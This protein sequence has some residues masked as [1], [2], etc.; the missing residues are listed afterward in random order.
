MSDAPGRMP[1]AA[2]YLAICQQQNGR[3]VE[4]KTAAKTAIPSYRERLISQ[5]FSMRNLVE[6]CRC[7]I[8]DEKEQ[9]AIQM[10]Q[11]QSKRC[12]PAELPQ[13]RFL[14][15]DAYAAESRRMRQSGDLKPDDFLKS[16]D[17]LARG[18]AFA[19]LNPR[20][21]DELSYLGCSTEVDEN[22]LQHRLQQA[23]DSGI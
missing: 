12:R 1:E 22:V 11:E 17:L 23:L 13:I 20:L 6:L 2:Y 4:A 16:L 14:M 15:G 18:L 5:P 3:L 7:L 10:M 9:Q 19:P 21:L 8:I